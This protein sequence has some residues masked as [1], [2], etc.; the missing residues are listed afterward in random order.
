M[1]CNTLLTYPNFDET[2]KTHTNAITF[3]LGAVISQK[4]K[5]ISF[6]S[7][8]LTDAQQR[9][10]VT[11]RELLS[12]VETMKEFRTILPGQKLLIY[13]DHK[14]LRVEISIPI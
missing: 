14:T 6:Y 7:I 3:Q 11:E 13:T 1:A 10:T 4:G 8:K 2:F 5:L 9:Y 12:I